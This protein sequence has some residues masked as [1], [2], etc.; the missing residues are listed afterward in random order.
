MRF[1]LILIIIWFTLS[2]I[3]LVQTLSSISIIPLDKTILFLGLPHQAIGLFILMF[4]GFVVYFIQNLIIEFSKKDKTNK[5]SIINF[6]MFMKAFLLV[7]ITFFSYGILA[8][9]TIFPSTVDDSQFL[10]WYIFWFFTFKLIGALAYYLSKK[11]N[12]HFSYG[13]GKQTYQWPE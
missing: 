11:Y 12:Q 1:K 6:M 2:S 10:N 5:K 4:T 7:W 8:A 13:S 3:F 9:F